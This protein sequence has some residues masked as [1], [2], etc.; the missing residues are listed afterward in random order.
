MI[1]YLLLYC[2][3]AVMALTSDRA[4][5]EGYLISLSPQFRSGC[6][7]SAAAGMLALVVWHCV[8]ERWLWLLS[9][10]MFSTLVQLQIAFSLH[11]RRWFPGLGVILAAATALYSLA[12]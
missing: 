1:I 12:E 5:T 3:L 7:I 6:Q 4:R 11:S 8:H 9:L 10:F 2:L